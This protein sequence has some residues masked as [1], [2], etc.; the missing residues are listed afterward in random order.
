ALRL[1]GGGAWVGEALGHSDVLGLEVGPR[2]W[3]T[4]IAASVR[5]PY[6]KGAVKAAEEAGALTGSISNNKESDISDF[7][8]FPVEVA[9]GPEILPGYTRLKAGTTQKLVL[10][11]ISAIINIKRVKVYGNYM[12]DVNPSNRKLERRAINMIREITDTE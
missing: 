9:S 7:A 4:G 11:M 10:N 8:D 3:V 6:V 5:P 2:Y 12:V 1:A